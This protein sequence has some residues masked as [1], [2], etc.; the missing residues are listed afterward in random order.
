MIVTRNIKELKSTLTELREKGSIGFVPTMGALHVGH[1]SLIEKSILENTTT[2]ASVFVNPTQFNDKNDLK[3]Y[4]RTEE[5]DFAMLESAGCDVVFA[6]QS[7]E[8]Y[9]EVD[10]RV[11]DF[12]DLATVMEGASRPGHFNGVAQVVSKLFSYVEPDNAYFGE[13]DFQQVSIIKQMCK[14]TNLSLNIVVC[15]IIRDVD[16][17]ALSSRNA[18][19]TV[20]NRAMAPIIYMTLKESLNVAKWATVKEVKRW[21]IEQIESDDRLKCDYFEIV[22]SLTLQ[23]IEEWDESNDIQGCIAVKLGAIRLIDNINFRKL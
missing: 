23:P 16:G 14:L 9:P 2:V 18:L 22:D 6:P 7:E 1:I 5:A 10:T 4:P 15:P 21:V 20:E 8:V 3:N 19:L 17:L 13:K 11:F 12:K